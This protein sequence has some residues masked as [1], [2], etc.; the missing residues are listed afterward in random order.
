MDQMKLLLGSAG[1]WHGMNILS[2]PESGKPQSSS[3]ALVITPVV[4]GRFVRL[5]YTWQYKGT[6][7]EGLLLVGFNRK[8]EEFSGHWIDTW[9]MGDKV[10]ACSGRN[11]PD[12][13][14][15][16]RGAY[17]APPGPDWGWRIEITPDEQASLQL[18]MFNIW[19]DGKREEL[20]VE[21]KYRRAA[22]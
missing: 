12:G 9:H 17:A 7:Q 14:I 18:I 10:M 6:P 5:D 13:T 11:S 2:D 8:A 15:A 21:A 22:G 19:P 1:K 16:L 3:S 4:G 20:A